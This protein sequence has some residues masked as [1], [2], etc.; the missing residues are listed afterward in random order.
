[1]EVKP[2]SLR[3]HHYQRLKD[4]RKNYFGGSLSDLQAAMLASTATPCSC[5]MCG[6]P[7]RYLNERS[8]Q[9][10]RL[11]DNWLIDMM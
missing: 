7:R 3:R 10:R 4:K 9:E 1:M 6:N 8:I 5:F 2:R 11:I